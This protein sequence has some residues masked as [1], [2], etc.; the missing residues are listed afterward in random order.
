MYNRIFDLPDQMVEALKISSVWKFDPQL[1]TDVKNVVIVG[2]GGSAIGGD[3]ARSY[4]ADKLLVPFHICRH[5]QLP[6]YVDD[7]TLVIASSYSGNTEETLAAVD[8]AI[9]RKSMIAG[10]STGGMLKEVATLNEIPIVKMPAGLPP[11]AALGF[12]FVPLMVFLEKIGLIKRSQEEIKSVI[13]KLSKDRDNYME[14][15]DLDSNVAKQIAKKIHGR[16]PIIYTGPTLTDVVGVRW[17]GQICE[18]AKNLAFVNQYP[19]YNHNELVGWSE[20]MTQHAD[21][22][23]VLTLRDEDD[24]PQVS[25]RMEVVKPLLEEIGVEVIE[26]HSTGDSSMQR[27]FSLIQLGDFVSYYLAILNEVDPTPVEVIDMLKA[28]LS[29]M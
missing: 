24:H 19:E 8:D 26:I 23:I 27:M 10:I 5:Y 29:E 15:G 17:K 22:L 21:K 4:L 20:L 13:K 9:A 3:L 12:S 2:M 25:K 7:E 6:E 16:I 1:F 28:A 18:N 11:R 14:D